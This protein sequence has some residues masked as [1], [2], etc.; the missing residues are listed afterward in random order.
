METLKEIFTHLEFLGY[1]IK[2]GSNDDGGSKYYLALHPNLNNQLILEV[3]PN[4]ITFLGRSTSSKPISIEMIKYINTANVSM[5][6]S[7]AY[8]EKSEEDKTIITFKATYI[9][10]YSKQLFGQFCNFLEEDQHIFKS[11]EH[12]D[13]LF[14]N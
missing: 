2:D 4:F 3:R 13:E 7:N 10:N 11:L 9:G 12:F 6:I 1:E 8:Y 14:V 5:F